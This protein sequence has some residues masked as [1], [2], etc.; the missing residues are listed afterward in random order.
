[1]RKFYCYKIDKGKTTFFRVLIGI[2][3][4]LPTDFIV[5]HHAINICILA[6]HPQSFGEKL[7]MMCDRQ[8][9]VV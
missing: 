1:L 6:H 3:F 9:L 2:K 8:Q 4:L 7:G 5:E